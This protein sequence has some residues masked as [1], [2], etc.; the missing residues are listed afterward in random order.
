MRRCASCLRHD[1]RGATR[2]DFHHERWCD[3]WTHDH[4]REQRA[5]ETRHHEVP[6][7]AAAE[8]LQVFDALLNVRIAGA[9]EAP[10]EFV[11]GCLDGTRRRLAALD[12]FLD[13]SEQDRI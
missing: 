9:P 7:Y 5:R 11:D 8:V 13:A 2:F 4:L 6:E 12:A 10:L 3:A 1:G